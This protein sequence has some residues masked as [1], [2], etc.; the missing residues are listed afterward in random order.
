MGLLLVGVAAGVVRAI[1][2][3]GCALAAGRVMVVAVVLGV[4]VVVV[5]VA[6]SATPGAALEFEGR[7]LDSS[8]CRRRLDWSNKSSCCSTR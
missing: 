2:R 5:G 4:G 6:P 3:A 8:A 7:C 1:C